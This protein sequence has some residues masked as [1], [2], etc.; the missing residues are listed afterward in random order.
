MTIFFSAQTGG[1]YD[2]LIH[3]ENIPTGAVKITADQHRDLL[4]GQRLG[5]QIVAG[6][7]GRPVLEEVAPPTVAQAFRQFALVLQR[8][9]DATVA[10]RGY[11]NGIDRA[12]TWVS[13]SNPRFVEEAVAMS[14]WRDDAWAAHI[15]M[16]AACE[17]TESPA[18]VPAD[19]DA[20]LAGI[21]P[22]VWP[23]TAS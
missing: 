21:P 20:Y 18:P 8:H 5:R 6:P 13:S 9:L 12:T 16:Q 22:L 10:A 19:A 7:R 1:F 11:T 4:E 2:S 3:G 14:G 15:R 23:A 17:A